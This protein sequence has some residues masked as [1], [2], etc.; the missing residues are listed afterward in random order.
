MA[1]P[2][3][4]TGD[5]VGAPASHWY[6]ITPSDSENLTIRPRAL[7]LPVGGDVAL[8]DIDGN[9][10]TFTLA[11]GYHPLRPNRV[12]ATGTTADLVIVALY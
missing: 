7:F 10:I 4:K 1:N 8:R 12:L 2:V 11:A 3:E 5:G 6:T 9:D